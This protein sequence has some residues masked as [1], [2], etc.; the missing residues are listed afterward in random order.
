[1]FKISIYLVF[2]VSV[3]TLS[4][5]VTQE[6]QDF[7][8][9][10]ESIT[11]ISNTNTEQINVGESAQL[12]AFVRSTNS[13]SETV[14]WSSSNINIV[15]V[16]HGKIKGIAPGEATITVTS[17]ADRAKTASV[18]I[19]VVA[20]ITSE[21]ISATNVVIDG[22][23]SRSKTLNDASETLMA[24][25]IPA[26]STENIVWSSDPSGKVSVSGEVTFDALGELQVI[27]TAGIYA[28]TVT[29]T[30]VSGVVLATS[31]SIAVP[32]S[33]S[34]TLNDA[35]ETLMATI[36]PATSTENIVWSSDPS[37]KVSVS[38][39]VTFD[40]L[41]EL[42]VIAT[43]G[44]YADTVTYTVVSGVVL[45][46]S[47]SI[48]VP[49]S[50]SKTLND[51]SETL[52][53][54]IIPATSTEN[55]V[56]S[57]DPSGKVSVSGEVT[58]DALGELQVIA[59]A[60]IYAD[61]VTYTVVSGVVLATSVSIAVPSSLS[62]TLNDASETLMAT[63][64]PATS[65]ENIV[66]S[67]DPSG[68]VSVSGEVTFDALG[69][70]KVIVT[71][72]IYA[73][74]VTY[75]V[76]SGVVLATSVSIAVPS[77]LSKTLNDASE[78]LMATIIPATSTENIVWSS[79]PSGKVSVSGEVTFDA[80]GELKV[81][82][83]AGIYADTVTYTVVS[84][85]VLATSVSIAVPSS[86]SKTLNDA[87]ETL[88]ATIIPA[89]STE[90]IV[91]SSDPSGKVSV[92]G[93]V[94]FDALGELKVIA[95]AGIY[96]DTV[97]YT[98]VSG[99]VLATSVSIAVP[100]SL[101]KTLN[102]ASETLMATIIPATSTENIV[103]SSDPSGKVSVSGEVTFDA[104]GELKVIATAGI[105]AD[106]VTYTVV[107]GVVL[108]TSVSIAV[109][110]SLSKTLNDAS[111]TLMATIIPATST[112][113][114]VWSSDPSGKVSA[115]GEVTFDALGEL[116]VIATAG[117]YA[118][119]VTYTVVS[120]VVLATSVSLDLSMVSVVLLETTTVSETVSPSNATNQNVT[121]SSDAEEVATVVDGIITG[122]SVGMA[123][124]TVTTVDGGYTATVGVTVL[125]PISSFSLVE[126]T[127]IAIVTP[128]SRVSYIGNI[129]TYIGIDSSS[130]KIG[131]SLQVVNT[132]SSDTG[133]TW[134]S[135]NSSVVT[136]DEYGVI[137]VVGTQ[138][139]TGFV[140][141][142]A[143]SDAT[144][145]DTVVVILKERELISIGMA[146]ETSSSAPARLNQV[147][148]N[149]IINED[150][151][152]TSGFE[153]KNYTYKW[154][155]NYT[156]GVFAYYGHP[157]CCGQRLSGSTIE[158]KLSGV[159]VFLYTIQSVTTDVVI[160]IVLPSDIVFDEMILTFLGTNQSHRE[161]ETQAL[162]Q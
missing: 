146:P 133:I 18:T 60:G 25:I 48:A 70:L 125:S 108:A 59:T 160:P 119:T 152:S 109:P 154:N 40:A 96:A 55:I 64:I 10:V 44:I 8:S 155:T 159:S 88:M 130:R 54:T 42:Q 32:S 4:S 87:S 89:T 72:G 47:V 71:A 135:S 17:E 33:L 111:E 2:S 116:K 68:K 66:W 118:D 9:K 161:I 140:I 102:D 157:T 112:E 51:A 147:K 56:W 21:V 126:D 121:W 67:S 153:G 110:S 120:G 3:F 63:I 75:T 143:T 58:F 129:L 23:A 138:N 45:A 30:V 141:A 50:L 77:S 49:S 41:G 99:V 132:G 11:L 76:V 20:M 134:L 19:T 137:D 162:P 93:E 35:S 73:D 107:S 86:L 95:T 117:I 97:T 98:V 144:K 114:I 38:G 123:T 14:I 29:Y 15:T 6:T 69:E 139:D 81:I 74:T 28:D 158:F 24:T 27:A 53:A 39:E 84:G 156:H 13:A 149:G 91:W 43:A 100:S 31:V 12:S 78:T 136:V 16:I 82:A 57:S 106:T 124:I 150:S 80:L 128:S 46:T 1:M 79:D 101:S 65:T 113:N 85:V 83:T 90:N 37:G 151:Y 142:Y 127:L 122:V 7:S 52:M 145:A 22:D 131:S 103:W 105:Y 26:T 36:I 61:T 34:K 115:S 94:T 92:S 104:L 148:F 62:K 5:C